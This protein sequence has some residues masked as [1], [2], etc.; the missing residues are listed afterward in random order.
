MVKDKFDVC[1]TTY[2]GILICHSEL[3]KHK[4]QYFIVDEA[5][6]LKNKDS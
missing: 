3:K 5:H 4:W 2:E 1:I 6:K